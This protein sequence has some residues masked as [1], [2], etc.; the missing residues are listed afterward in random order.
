M[1]SSKVF[2]FPGEKDQ[3]IS[4]GAICITIDSVIDN[5]DTVICKH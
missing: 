4:A 5:I 3:H 1:E 2:Q